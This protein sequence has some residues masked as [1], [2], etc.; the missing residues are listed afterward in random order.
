VNAAVVLDRELRAESRRPVNYWLRVLAA[1]AIIL[2]FASFVLSTQLGAGLGPALFMVLHRTLFWASWVLVPLMTAD[3]IS[4]ERREGTLGLLFLTPLT[5][6]DVILGKGATHILRVLTLFLAALPVLG[7]PFMLGGVGWR[8][9]LLALAS[10]AW[11]VLLGIAA[12]IY[13]STRGGTTIQVMMMAEAYALSLAIISGTCQTFVSW[14]LLWAPRGLLGDLLVGA[15]C[16]LLLFSL[17]VQQSIRRLQQTWQEESAAPEQPRWVN[18]FSSSA[19]WQDMFRWNKSRTLDRNPI[20]WLQEYSWTAR[21]TKWGWFIFLLGAE[22]VVL[23]SWYTPRTMGWQP[24]LTATLAAGIAFSAAG[25]FRRE[26]QA[27]LLELLLVTPLSVRQ[28]IGGRIWGIGCHFLPAIGLLLL[29]WTGDHIL[30]PRLFQLGLPDSMFMNPAAFC[31]IVLLGLYLSLGQLNFLLG[32]TLTWVAAFVLPLVAS[33]ALVRS[34]YCT[35]GTALVLTTS[36]QLLLSALVWFLLDRTL[37]Q[38][39][40]LQA[41]TALGP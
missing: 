20:A 37:R 12:G 10:E 21:L 3:C 39:T 9:T 34:A 1:G 14:T 6:F 5:A 23:V 16:N 7:L 30:N 24:W 15:L 32:W 8:Q 13:A 38:R 33:L 36:L 19:F 28:L 18:L 22:F 11:A 26:R 2:V 17:V 25:S 35:A 41:D 4:R 27:G 40:F 31:L 29:G